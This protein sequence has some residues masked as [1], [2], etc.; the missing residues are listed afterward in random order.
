M[1]EQRKGGREAERKKRKDSMI[2][3]ASGKKLPCV[4]LR[5]EFITPRR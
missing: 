4:D 1:E 3:S 5:R 2:L